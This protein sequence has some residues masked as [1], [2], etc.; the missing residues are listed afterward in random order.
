[1]KLKL[2]IN[3]G[4]PYEEEFKSIED[5][6]CKLINLEKEFK[7]NPHYDIIILRDNEEITEEVFK[8]YSLEFDDFFGYVN[9]NS[10]IGFNDCYEFKPY[11]NNLNTNKL[12]LKRL[13]KWL[14]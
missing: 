2:I 13:K 3:N 14:K 4:K 11:W 12:N 8:N 10:T 7:E 1:M 9:E 6:L 5:L